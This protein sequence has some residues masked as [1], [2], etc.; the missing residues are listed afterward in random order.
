MTF[1]KQF[2]QKT[3]LS[4]LSHE[5]QKT[6]VIGKKVGC[7]NKLVTNTLLEMPEVEW[8]WVKGGKVGTR[9][10]RLKELE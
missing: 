2:P 8:R 9:E 7:K 3:F 10:W 1:K 6:S 5:W 4:T